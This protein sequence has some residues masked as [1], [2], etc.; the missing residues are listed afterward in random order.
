MDPAAEEFYPH[1]P[2]SYVFNNPIIYIDPDG[3]RP[4]RVPHKDTGKFARKVATTAYNALPE[5]SKRGLNATW[6]M[7]AGVGQAAG[8]AVV[9]IKTG[10]SGAG[11]VVGLLIFADGGFRFVT[12]TMQMANLLDGGPANLDP[13]YRTIL[14]DVFQSETLEL[15]SGAT[16]SLV[17]VSPNLIIRL[18]NAGASLETIYKM[19]DGLNNGDQTNTSKST[20][21]ENDSNNSANQNEESTEES[22]ENES[23]ITRFRQMEERLQN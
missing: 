21:S 7:T 6:N 23:W 2:Y 1:S 15:L 3:R 4:G 13:Q 20:S 12:G 17:T 5:N 22:D 10:P 8:G 11:A 18:I 19:L 16:T 14:G 9:A